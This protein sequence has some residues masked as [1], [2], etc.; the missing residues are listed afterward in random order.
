MNTGS[1]RQYGIDLLR[2]FACFSLLPFHYCTYG[3]MSTPISFQYTNEVI[4][5]LFGF[6]VPLFLMIGGALFLTKESISIKRLYAHNI[7]H[8]VLVYGKR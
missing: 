2:I 7:A 6:H 8:I 4:K 1:S 5:S 3:Q